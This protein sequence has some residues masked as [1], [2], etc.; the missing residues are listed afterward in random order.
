[1]SLLGLHL[2][3]Y[4]GES[5]PTPVGP[6]TIEAL[7]TLEVTHTDAGRSAFQ[8]V[9]QLRSRPRRRLLK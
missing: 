7:Q 5:V 6:S 8:L 2:T 1:M 3:L 4:M 9:F